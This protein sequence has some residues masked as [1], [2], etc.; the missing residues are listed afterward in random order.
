M[1]QVLPIFLIGLLFYAFSRITTAG[2]Y[3]TEKTAFS[4]LCVYAESLLM[5]VLLFILP[6]FMGQAGVWWSAVSAQILTADIALLLLIVSRKNDR[7]N[8]SVK[9]AV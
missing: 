4:Y 6:L 9:E 3:A 5:L 7:V 8:S 2:F 1:A